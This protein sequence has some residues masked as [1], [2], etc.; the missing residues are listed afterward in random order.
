MNN[1]LK[2][3]RF[4]DGSSFLV[5]PIELFEICD[6]FASMYGLGANKSL[7]EFVDMIN[8]EDPVI[9]NGLMDAATIRLKATN[10][11]SD[12]NKPTIPRIQDS[13]PVVNDNNDVKKVRAS[14]Q[15][16]LTK[17]LREWGAT[18]KEIKEAKE[19]AKNVK[20]LRDFSW[21]TPDILA[22]DNF[23][24]KTVL[25]QMKEDREKAVN[26]NVSLDKRLSRDNK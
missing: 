22:S 20:G 8:K 24:I 21:I 14:N 15:K 2:E 4:A 12:T 9:V 16:V 7:S 5:D 13:I 17:F 11:I 3:V 1:K 23:D 10:G 6:L 26:I 25:R 19:K 18:D